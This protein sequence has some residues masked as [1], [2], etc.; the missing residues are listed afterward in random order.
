MPWKTAATAVI[1]ATIALTACNNDNNDMTF[2]EAL[3]ADEPC[4]R[5]FEIRN[6]TEPDSPLIESMNEQLR[7]V[8]C[9]SSDSER[10]D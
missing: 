1:A 3:D 7:S 2:E 9:Y 4:T 5:L 10:T 8:G 6:D